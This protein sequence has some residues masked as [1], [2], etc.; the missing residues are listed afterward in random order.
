MQAAGRQAGRQHVARESGTLTRI[1]YAMRA[2]QA[3]LVLTQ[4]TMH[5]K[6]HSHVTLTRATLM[7]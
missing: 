2:A 7:R 3:L 5:V 1:K 6:A 4:E